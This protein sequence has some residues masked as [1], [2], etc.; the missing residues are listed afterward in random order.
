M[1]LEELNKLQNEASRQKVKGILLVEIQK[2][3]TEIKQLEQKQA[4]DQTKSATASKDTSSEKP[5]VPSGNR[6]VTTITTY[7]R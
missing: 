6:P 5:K 4:A 7:G 3:Q 2:L 1:D